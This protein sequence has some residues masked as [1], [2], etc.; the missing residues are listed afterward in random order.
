MKL[1]IS[2][3]LALVV[4]VCL[5]S[6]A[7][8]ADGPST[9]TTQPLPSAAD[10][11]STA[12][13]QLQPAD[14]SPAQGTTALDTFADLLGSSTSDNAVGL[15][16]DNFRPWPSSGVPDIFSVQPGVRASKEDF[17]SDFNESAEFGSHVWRMYGIGSDLFDQM[18]NPIYDSQPAEREYAAGKTLLDT[19]GA[20]VPEVGALS[21]I[22]DTLH[23]AQ[24]AVN[25][26]EY[27]Q[28]AHALAFGR[29]L[30]EAPI[31]GMTYGRPDYDYYSGSVQTLANGG[32]INSTGSWNAWYGEKANDISASSAYTFNDL[33]TYS[34]HILSG[35]GAATTGRIE[36]RDPPSWFSPF[37]TTDPMT[38]SE[39]TRRYESYNDSFNGAEENRLIQNAESGQYRQMEP[40]PVL[41]QTGPPE[42]HLYT[43]DIVRRPPTISNPPIDRPWPTPADVASDF[44]SRLPVPDVKGVLLPATVVKSAPTT[45]ADS[46]AVFADSGN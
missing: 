9:A 12:A 45:R 15:S 13:A 23:D 2:R 22:R 41:L 43:D 40:P 38:M 35:Y 24:L 18:T 29:A 1:A 25:A 39:T 6:Q 28:E 4:L 20:F 26:A 32:R 19:V 10:A 21:D 17:A 27:D 44:T 33:S 34:G 16:L 37:D 31:H 36:A 8:H 5:L 3:L 7:L 42:M 11:P 14:S 30:S 46:S